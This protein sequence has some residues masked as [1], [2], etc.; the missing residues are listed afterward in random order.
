MTWLQ[1]TVDLAQSFGITY[2]VARWIFA[3][4]ARIRRARTIEERA[5]HAWDNWD[6][7]EVARELDTSEDHGDEPEK[8]H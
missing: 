1:V 5:Q 6:D 2:C 8:R 3:D 4:R 7:T